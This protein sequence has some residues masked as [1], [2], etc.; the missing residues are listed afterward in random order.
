M[1][2]IHPEVD[3][4]DKMCETKQ[5][6]F[7]IDGVYAG[8]IF[9]GPGMEEKTGAG[10]QVMLYISQMTLN[11]CCKQHTVHLCTLFHIY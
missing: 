6:L 5:Q 10:E 4:Q 7:P 3:S 8:C 1:T 2:P 11:L 9:Y